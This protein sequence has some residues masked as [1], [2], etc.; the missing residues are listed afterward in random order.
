MLTRMEEILLLSVWKLQSEAYGLA[1]KQHVSRLLGRDLSV[2]AVYVPLKRLAKL[3][4]LES[5]Q[6][7]PTPNR[8][9]RR[10]RYYRLSRKGLTAL[11]QVK[12]VH[13][14]CWSGL[15]DLALNV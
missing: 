13:E 11:N 4:Y 10:A 9:G 14:E 5:W 8:G 2:P 3:G 15:P 7:D 6:S 1:V 12:L